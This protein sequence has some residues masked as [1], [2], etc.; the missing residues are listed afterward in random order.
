MNVLQCASAT[1]FCHRFAMLSCLNL[2]GWRGGR[3]GTG[4]QV[5]AMLML[6]S[7]HVD[8]TVTFR[9]TGRV[10]E[11][12]VIYVSC[13][14]W[15]LHSSTCAQWV[16]GVQYLQQTAASCCEK[17]QLV[18]QSGLYLHLTSF[19]Y[20][21]NAAC[22]P[23]C[24]DQMMLLAPFWQDSLHPKWIFDDLIIWLNN[25]IMLRWKSWSHLNRLMIL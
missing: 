17:T 13:R 16:I 14:F 12:V 23:C 21:A 1:C 8:I 10:F 7:H 3:G 4:R 20:N 19:P 24:T 25:R 22:V 15:F 2:I 6:H 9:M 18:S 5:R 11:H